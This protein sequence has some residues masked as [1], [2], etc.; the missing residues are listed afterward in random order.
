MTARTVQRR[1]G[2]GWFGRW[3]R[4]RAENT[5]K[6][7]GSEWKHR[8][9]EK[10]GNRFTTKSTGMINWIGRG[11]YD[12]RCDLAAKVA[13]RQAISKVKKGTLQPLISYFR[14]VSLFKTAEFLNEP[15]V[16]GPK[17]RINARNGID[18]RSRYAIVCIKQTYTWSVWNST[19]SETRNARCATRS[20]QLPGN[21]LIE[22]AWGLRGF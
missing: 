8:L 12:H 4:S 21:L 22:P 18:F 14:G 7:E 19:H 11:S 17:R 16:W 10:D 20:R 1:N 13:A 3:T 15:R 5:G 6:T 2:I 9:R